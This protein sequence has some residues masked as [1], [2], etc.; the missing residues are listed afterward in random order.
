M[1]HNLHVLRH[2]MALVLP[3]ISESSLQQPLHSK[4]GASLSICLHVL[5]LCS[6]NSVAV[7]PCQG[8]LHVRHNRVSSSALIA[9][10]T[11]LS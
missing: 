6:A 1:L 3:S 2:A 11:C 9:H 10:D 7:P 5:P 4:H 8:M